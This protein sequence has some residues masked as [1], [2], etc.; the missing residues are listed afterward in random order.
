MTYNQ[1][2]KTIITIGFT[3]ILFL[4]ALL[5]VMWVNSIA[6][7][8]AR[9]NI[10]AEEQLKTEMITRMRDATHRRALA[11]HRMPQ[12]DDPFDRD[13]EFIKIRELGTEFL[14]ARDNVID[15]RLSKE[16]EKAWEQV[17]EIMNKG[18]RAQM[19]VLRLITEDEDIEKANEV[20]LNEVVPTQDTFVDSISNVLNIVRKSVE[21]QLAQ[22][23][24]QNTQSYRLVALLGTVGLLLG[25]FTIFVIR[26]T[27]KTEEALMIQGERIRSL[28]ETS[29]ITGLPLEEHIQEMLK[30]GC[31]LFNMEYGKICHVIPEENANTIVTSVGPDGDAIEPGTIV[32]LDESLCSITINSP[33]PVTIHDNRG[34]NKHT[35]TRLGSDTESYI[36][37]QFV[38]NGEKFG[39]VSFYSTRPHTSTFSD[40]D[41]DLINLIGSWVSVALERLATQE[42]LSVAKETAEHANNSKSQFLANMS[43]ELRTPLNAIIGYSELLTEEIEDGAMIDTTTELDKIQTSGKHLLD[44]I[45]D[46][47]DLSKIEAGKM[48]IN[49]ERIQVSEIITEVTSTID[50]VIEH[51]NNKLVVNIDKNIGFINADRIR[52]KQVLYNLL[53]NA[54]KFTQDGLITINAYNKQINDMDWV[55]IDVKDTGIGMTQDQMKKLFLSFS[56]VDSSISQ[57]FGGTGLGLSISRKICRI[58]GGDIYVQSVADIGSTF[59]IELPMYACSVN[60]DTNAAVA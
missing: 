4:L 45:N 26:R 12:L 14:K 30:L 58:M 20:L 43:H 23:A 2:S 29:S 31:R 33:V 24:D 35:E 16:E 17:R 55:V 32:P 18:G 53:S 44:L 25:I 56:Q 34:S 36:G 50:G 1:S 54:S 42:E 49:P 5:I 27:S 57:R 6:E 11:L 10:I 8:K 40:T 60:T 41:K 28:Y 46:V 21:T 39:T 3:T 22:A 47:L 52:L 19:Q 38:V 7:N 15:K 51:N 9:L 59:S 13:E 37:T 48:D